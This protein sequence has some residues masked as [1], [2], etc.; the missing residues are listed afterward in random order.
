MDCNFPDDWG[1]RG[2]GACTVCSIVADNFCMILIGTSWVLRHG[3]ILRH[4]K[5]FP[6]RYITSLK[7][8]LPTTEYSVWCYLQG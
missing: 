4:G 5:G 8:K 6:S 7:H 1:T 3:K 2:G